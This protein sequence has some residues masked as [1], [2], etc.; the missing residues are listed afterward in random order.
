MELEDAVLARIAD[1]VREADDERERTRGILARLLSWLFQQQRDFCEDV[2]RFK[3]LLAPRGAGKTFAAV[4]L[5]IITALAFPGLPSRYVALT[6]DHAKDLIWQS[7]LDT[8][9]TLG[10]GHTPHLQSLTVILHNGSTIRLG[11]CEDESDIERY[12]GK[13]HKLF[14]VD[15]AKSVKIGIL[16]TLVDDI[17][18]PRLGDYHGTIIL[19]GTPGDIFSGMFYDATSPK[20]NVVDVKED[21]TLH[22][23]GRPYTQRFLPQWVPVE[24]EWSQHGWSLKDNTKCK[25]LWSE[26]LAQKRRKGWSDDNPIWRREYLGEWAEDDNKLVYR[27]ASERNIWTPGEKTDGNPYGLPGDHEWHYI[28]GLDMGY[29]DTLALEL[30]A[31][32]QTCAGLYEVTFDFWTGG[33]IGEVARRVRAMMERVGIDLLV[34]DFGTTGKGSTVQETL[35]CEH[36][37]AFKAAD[38]SN[39]RHYQTLLNSEM[40][41][42]RVFF[43]E[44]SPVVKEM[45]VLSWNDSGLKE[46][47]GQPNHHCDAVLYV[48]RES[49]HWQAK[50]PIAPPTPGTPEHAQR[51]REDRIAKMRVAEQCRQYGDEQPENDAAVI[52]WD[53]MPLGMGWQI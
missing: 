42:G 8:L 34:G 7:L 25:H 18:I 15:E 5:L 33:S 22:A 51:A 32:S 46:R 12:R 16:K 23:M 20:S 17:V 1:E 27:F 24:I 47:D 44:D 48:S 43:R 35:A 31:Y 28:L 50:E 39:K 37:L 6:R 38:K 29:S 10:V 52:A 36:G 11:G 13:A 40:I 26:A 9:S 3:T 19:M 2:A 53:E 4:A 21:G 30:M 14:I 41:E 45:S 49:M